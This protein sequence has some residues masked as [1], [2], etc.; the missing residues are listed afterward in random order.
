MKMS[1]NIPDFRKTLTDLVKSQVPFATALALNDT[2]VDVS[3]GEKSEMN[4]VLD[5]PTPFT[6][7]GFYQLRANKKKLETTIGVKRIQAKYLAYQIDGGIR[8]PKHRAILIPVGIRKNIYGNMAK[9]AVS[10]LLAQSGVFVASK[11]KKNTAHLRPGIYKRVKSRAKKRTNRRAAG[12]FAP[13]VAAP[14]LMVA[15]ENKAS[16]QKRFDFHGTAH[17]IAGQRYEYHFRRRL[18]A[19]LQS[20]R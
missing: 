12:S 20:A 8:K 16:Y 18:K 15:F 13:K 19:A 3:V 5:A 17:V 10:R 11:S 7:K 6:Q 1:H 4:A 14:K 2:G 9:G